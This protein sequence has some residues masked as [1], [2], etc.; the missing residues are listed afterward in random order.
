MSRKVI[1]TCAVTGGAALG[2]NAQYVPITPA[3]IAGECIAAAKA[4]AAIAHVHVRDPATGAPSMELAYY[5]ETVQRIRDSGV[6]LILNITTGPGARYAPPLDG[7]AGPGVKS[8]EARMVHVLELR[9]EIC[10]LDVATMNFGPTSAIVN[11]PDHL[12]VM[13]R[14]IMQAGIKPELE[15]FD[16]GH[17][18]L[19]KELLKSGH[20]PAPPMFQF[21]LGILGGAPATLPVL[22]LMSSLVPQD[23]VWSAFGVG[24]HQFPIAAHVVQLGGHVRVGLE[25]NLYLRRGELSKGNAPLVERAVS[26][27]RTLDHDIASPQDAREILGVSAL[28]PPVAA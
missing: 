25:D 24:R 18:E 28:S 13:G 22:Q 17:L 6:D 27:I 7:S 23:A 10:T 8:P 15:V 12:R 14:A 1:V 21:C 3:Q 19:A 16:L 5:R 11:T 26:I 20:L 9:P 2:K 4:G